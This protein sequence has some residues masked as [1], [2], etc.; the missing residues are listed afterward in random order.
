[1][2]IFIDEHRER[3]GVEPICQELP[4]APSTYYAAKSRPPSAR[5][6]RDAELEV[7][8]KRIYEENFSVYGARKVWRQ[9]EREGIQAARSTV[10]RLMRKL[11]LEGAVR[12]K[13]FKTTDP[14]G[15]TPPP[16][17]RVDRNFTVAAPN[18]LWVA[19]LTH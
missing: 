9:L 15:D 1:M 18:R 13:A 10:E 17:D 12:G 14:D 6:L 8:I 19:D 16:P 7:E 4:I 2:I 3:Y 5:S 11:G